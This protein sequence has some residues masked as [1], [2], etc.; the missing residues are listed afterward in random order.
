MSF[1]PSRFHFVFFSP[2]AEVTAVGFSARDETGSDQFYENQE[3]IVFGSELTNV[4]SNYQLESSTFICP[5]NGVYSFTVTLH[6]Q[7]FITT[8]DYVVDIVKEGVGLVT[9][10]SN[11]KDLY[12]STGSVTVECLRGER[13]WVQCNVSVGCI[14]RNFDTYY[15]NMFSGFLVY[16]Y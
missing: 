10:F 5:T 1:S 14:M 11:Y 7:E 15:Y 9:V 6:N 2:P 12:Q 16:A 8:Q 3:I 13:V 4:G